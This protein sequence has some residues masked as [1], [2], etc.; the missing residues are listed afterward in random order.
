MGGG[1]S[2][3]ACELATAEDARQLLIVCPKRVIDVWGAQLARFAPQYHAVLLGENAGD[4]AHKLNEARRYIAWGD[5]R[6]K[7]VAL[8]INYD[9]ARIQ[10]FANWAATR[11]WDMV[12][13]DELHR[14]KENRGRTSIFMAKLGLMARRRLGL[15]G[16]PMPHMPIDIWAQFRFL[17]PYHLEPT[18]GQFK[19]K[20]A[21]MGGYFDREVKGWR[22]LDDLERRFR[23]LAFR[24][25]DS[26][27]DLPPEMDEIRSTQLSPQGQR[28]YDEMEKQMIAWITESA[29]VTAANALVKLLRLEQIT[30]GW[31][32][33]EAGVLRQCDAAKEALL[34]EI[35]E[36]LDEPVV[37][38]CRFRSDLDAIARVVGDLKRG[39]SFELSGERDELAEWQ[40]GA[41]GAKVLA[42]QIQ[43][44]GIGVDLTRARVAIFYSLDF[45]LANYLQARARIRRPPQQRP[46]LFLHLQ[47]RHS[48][49]EYILR[50]VEAR[51]DLVDSVLNELKTK[52]AKHVV[53]G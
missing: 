10:P 41:S 39:P 42:V 6:S 44:G 30:S 7:P 43:A 1:K 27:L 34:E 51:G 36:D 18:Y 38:F 50:A 13:G 24:V 33:D 5:A 45:S 17:N 35:L 21:V 4:G 25:D 20:Y 19:L 2:R 9:A 49:D 12:I 26:V 52:G 29:F 22:D 48:I 53:A 46:C 23:E 37:V 15:T 47:V 40:R 8:V 11:P 3:V 28:I 16:T 14:C 32:P 31:A